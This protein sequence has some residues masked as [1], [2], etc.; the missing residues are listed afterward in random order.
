M[1]YEDMHEHVCDAIMDKDSITYPNRRGSTNPYHSN[2]LGDKVYE[3]SGQLL[4]A[5]IRG[6]DQEIL[7][8]MKYI[9]HQEIESII[10][11]VW[12]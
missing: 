9:C 5:Y 11:L 12:G 3:H 10:D 7:N 8:I 6:D 2:D 4:Q 1:K